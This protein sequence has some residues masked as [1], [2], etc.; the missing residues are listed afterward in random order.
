MNPQ[1]VVF[2]AVGHRVIRY[3][4]RLVYEVA[5]DVVIL[6]IIIV[7]LLVARPADQRY[8][9]LVVN[10]TC[11]VTTAYTP[12]KDRT[13]V[14]CRAAERASSNAVPWWY[15]TAFIRARNLTDV[16]IQDVTNAFL[17]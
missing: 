9:A 4:V 13:R 3:A 14:P 10:P 16:S 7:A 8:R 5:L 11:S 1:L 12:M 6:D 17:M 2:H 15:T